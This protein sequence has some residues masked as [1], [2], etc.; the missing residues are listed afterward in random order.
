MFLEFSKRD[1]GD[2]LSDVDELIKIGY[3][4][5]NEIMQ[6]SYIDVKNIF[7]MRTSQEQKEQLR[8]SSK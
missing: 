2:I 4:S 3:G 1:L 8:N 7:T 5:Y 6:L